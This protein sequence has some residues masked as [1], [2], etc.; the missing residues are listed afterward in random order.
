M[1]RRQGKRFER[2]VEREV[3]SKSGSRRIERAHSQK[4]GGKRHKGRRE[5][6]KGAE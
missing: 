3:R 4:R 5:M 1:G 2:G 6:G